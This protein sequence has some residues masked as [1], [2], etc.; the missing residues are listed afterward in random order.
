ME[1]IPVGLLEPRDFADQNNE[2]NRWNVIWER[3][4]NSVQYDVLEKQLMKMANGD[5][6]DKDAKIFDHRN[7]GR[8][9][10]IVAIRFDL[11]R[12]DVSNLGPQSRRA[13][14]RWASKGVG[15]EFDK[16]GFKGVMYVDDGGWRAM[17]GRGDIE[18]HIQKGIAESAHIV[19]LRYGRGQEG[20][21]KKPKN[22]LTQRWVD[23]RKSG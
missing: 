20:L 4:V 6:G 2:N 1:R 19:D 13:A 7:R 18:E 16:Y 22:T 9:T 23:A 10:S 12:T 15:L 11:R 21:E 14:T 8:I 17:L 3:V 5:S